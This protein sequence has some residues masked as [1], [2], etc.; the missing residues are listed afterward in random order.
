ML[1]SS[2]YGHSGI[3][4]PS[5]SSPRD[6]SKPTYESTPVATKQTPL[7]ISAKP[8]T[9]PSIKGPLK[10]DS[11]FFA[12]LGSS[13]TPENRMKEPPEEVPS[14]TS[15]GRM[16]H[17]S[18]ASYTEDIHFEPLIPL[19]EQIEVQTGEEDETT[20]F[21]SRAKLYRYD[22]DVSAWKERGIG[23]MKILHNSEKGRSRILMRREGV[24]KVCANHVITAD[25]KLEEKKAT[26]NCWIWSTLADFSEEVARAEQLAVKFK[27]PDEFLLFKEKFE[28][29]QEMPKKD[30]KSQAI[31]AV[32]YNPSA[33]LVTKFAPKPGSWSCSVCW[34]TNDVSTTVCVACGAQK[35]SEGS[36]TSTHQ[37]PLKSGFHL[38][39]E[40][41]ASSSP[42]TSM[43]SSC[44]ENSSSGS[45]FV[46][47]QKD[48]GSPSS[49]PFTFA[50]ST[51]SSSTST[52]ASKSFSFGAPLS[53]DSKKTAAQGDTLTATQVSEV[54]SGSP[55]TAN[56]L[57]TQPFGVPAM[58]NS[59]PSP[60]TFGTVSSTGSAPFSFSETQ[61]L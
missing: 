4:E 42:Q 35:L 1:Q 45:P 12:G 17:D 22:K 51:A 24:H 34:V 19:P 57:S 60:F 14:P 15:P 61:K 47:K 54:S 8:L 44:H 21:S 33:E 10:I 55:F 26:A 38:P 43:L 46:F 18:S 53:A 50:F 41:T 3:A 56:P 2:H 9:H 52:A 25:M 30:V 48:A 29:C 13:N 59:T 23:T 11:N 49:S 37:S 36:G 7:L 20:M 58:D 5:Y 28:E 6:Q 40:F 31:T 39:K 16:R 27:T 32:S